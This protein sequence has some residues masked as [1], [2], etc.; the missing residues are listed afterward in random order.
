MQTLN[1]GPGD[2][3]VV[4]HPDNTIDL[5]LPAGDEKKPLSAPHQALVGATIGLLSDEDFRALALQTLAVYNDAQP[6]AE[7]AN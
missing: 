5:I 4:I 1:L 2:Y 3:G 6:P 7:G